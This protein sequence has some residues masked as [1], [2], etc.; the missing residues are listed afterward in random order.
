MADW[1]IAVPAWGE[2]CLDAFLGVV[3]PSLR[4][5]LLGTRGHVRWVVHTDQPQRVQARFGKNADLTLLPEPDGDKPHGQ[6]GN[7][8]RDAL[9]MARIGEAVALVNADMVPSVEMFSAAERRFAEGKRCIVMTGTRTLSD[10]RPPV[11]AASRDLLKWAWDHQH[12]WIKGTTWGDGKTRTPALIHFKRGDTVVLH[13]FHLHPFAVLKEQEITF[14]GIT[15]DHDLIEKFPREQVHIVTSADEAAFAE[16]SPAERSF[17]ERPNPIDATFV[18]D[19]ATRPNKT[20]ATH[21][22]LFT[23]RICLCGEDKDIGDAAACAD[24]LATIERWEEPAPG[25]QL[26]IVEQ[27]RQERRRQRD[28]RLKNRRRRW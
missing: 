6:L 14:P 28:L 8:N 18:A 12:P 9:S 5:A 15:T 20:T 27:R 1:L 16:M 4:L 3:L 17:G 13:G 26:S 25:A 10:D 21:R 2:R 7:A 24:I 23:H 22:W 11:G 19:W